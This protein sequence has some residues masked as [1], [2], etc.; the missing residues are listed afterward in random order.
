MIDLFF[1]FSL[2]CVQVFLLYICSSG[3]FWR[4]VSRINT[5]LFLE[6][7][8]RSKETFGGPCS[9]ISNLLPP[10]F[11]LGTFIYWILHYLFPEEKKKKSDFEAR[12]TAALNLVAYNFP[13]TEDHISEV[14]S[15]KF[16]SFSSLPSLPRLCRPKIS[17]FI[18]VL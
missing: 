17:W 12:G 6:L 16:S 10:E 3:A 13:P 18:P 4:N 8:K 11:V 14:V 1:L 5:G 2:Q 9:R 15:S 7:E